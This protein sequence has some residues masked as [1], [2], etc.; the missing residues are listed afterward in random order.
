MLLLNSYSKIPNQ[1][2]S[3]MKF[4][5]YN[6]FLFSFLSLTFLVSFVNTSTATT[7]VVNVADFSFTPSSFTINLGDT[8]TWS[9]VGGT[10]TTSSTTVPSGASTWSAN[11]NSSHKTF[12]YV[13]AV[14]GTYNYQCNIHPSLMM[15]SFTVNCP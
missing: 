1:N 5:R 8:V 2:P 7:Q 10:H 12:T 4:N 11:I 6:F 3:P 15:G 14:T 9:W 13:P